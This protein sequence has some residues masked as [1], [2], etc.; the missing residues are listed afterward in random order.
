MQKIQYNMKSYDP[1]NLQNIS[2][3]YMQKKLKMTSKYIII[4]F[5]IYIYQAKTKYTDKNNNKE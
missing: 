2:Q 1:N 4:H 5:N 3:K